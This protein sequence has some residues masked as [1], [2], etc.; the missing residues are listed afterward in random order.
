VTRRIV[1]LLAVGLVVIVLSAGRAAA[2]APAG[3]GLV[4]DEEFNESSF[5]NTQFGYQWT[6]YPGVDA[7]SDA[8]SVTNGNL[9]MKAY[10]TYSGTTPQANWG[11]CVATEG[12]ARPDG[13]VPNYQFTYGYVEARIQFNNNYG[14]NPAF[15]LESDQMFANPPPTT[16]APGNEVDI[17]EQDYAYPNQDAIDI[18]WGGYGSGNQSW[19]GHK[20]TV[21]DLQNNYHVFGLLWTPTEYVFSVDGTTLATVTSSRMISQGPEFIVL[22]IDPNNLTGNWESPPA[23]GYGSL[24]TS[25]TDINVDYV[26]VYQALSLS[27]QSIGTAVVLTWGN[28]AFSLQAAPFV[29]GTYTNVPGATSPYT[30]A[31]SNAM[32][33]FRLQGN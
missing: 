32:E 9:T 12:Y 23:G 21:P 28:P 17:I 5:N 33:F 20:Y 25:T 1:V 6:G 30:N 29:T 31:V 11:G 16:A 14:C 19:G 13:S 26:R 24:T 15:W 3:Y 2:T 4:F 27:I 18:H 10:T 22:D 8:V 7:T